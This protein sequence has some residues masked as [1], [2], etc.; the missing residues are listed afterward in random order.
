MGDQESSK[1]ISQ[2]NNLIAER[3]KEV[4]EAA[5]EWQC[6]PITLDERQRLSGYMLNMKILQRRIDLNIF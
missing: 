6:F 4:K 1:S 2:E 5:G 3:R